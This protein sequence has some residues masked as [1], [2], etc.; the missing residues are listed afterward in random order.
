MHLKN[1]PLLSLLSTVGITV[2]TACPA[3]ADES[4]ILDE[5]VVKDEQG[6]DSKALETDVQITREDIT[7]SQPTDLKQ[8]FSET[9]SVQVSGGSPASQKILVH[10]V[11]E[12]KVN[13]TVDGARQNQ[14]IWHHNSDFG[15][16]P[17]FLK[18][19]DVN[20]GVSPADAGP[21]AIGG[22]IAFETID[23]V[24]LLEDGRTTGAL[25]SFGY[26]TNSETY[27]LTQSAYGNANGFD[28]LAALTRAEAQDYSDGDGTTEVGTAVDLWTGLAKV[29]Y[30]TPEGHRLSLSGEYYD[31]EGIRRQRVNMRE[32]TRGGVPTGNATLSDQVMSRYSTVLKYTNE[33]ATG[34]LDPEVLLYFNQTELDLSQLDGSYG[35]G[36]F[37]SEY[38]SIGGHA[39]NTFNFGMGS[40]TAGADFYHDWTD[41]GRDPTSSGTLNYIDERITNIG[42]YFQARLN[43]AERLEVSTGLRADYQS[44]RSVDEKTFEN[45]GLSPN[46]NLGYRLTEELTAKAGYSYVFGGIEQAETALFHAADYTYADDLKPAYAH[47]AKVGLEYARNGFTLGG[48]LFYLRNINTVDLDFT[49]RTAPVR[50]SGPDLTS[51]GID[52]HARY[53]WDSAYVRAAFSHSDVELD[54]TLVNGSTGDNL[55]QPVGSIL[56]L[57]GAYT[58]QDYDFTVGTDTEIAFEYSDQDLADAGFTNPLPGYVVVN[59]FAEWKPDFKRTKWT[60]RAEANNIF[61]ETYTARGTYSQSSVVTVPLRSPGRSFYLTATAKF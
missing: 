39:Q 45:F 2:L 59:A 21:G 56:T 26:D 22:S 35:R 15:I 14:N 18:S 10:G 23:A 32:V 54:G 41:I 33:K 12:T 20:T 40:V 19:V 5:V 31:D 57:A 11:D 4:K 1:Q 38:H 29:S 43:P 47:N 28:F 24:D 17:L 51:M 27:R 8:L 3:W 13:I 61:D 55:G 25:V 6:K 52:L 44:Y 49:V 58:F 50:R 48:E 37:T 7:R 16:D 9:P 36:F 42:T 46:I 53:D 30:E 34:L 60:L